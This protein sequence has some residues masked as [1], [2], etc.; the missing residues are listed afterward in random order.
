MEKHQIPE[1]NGSGFLF[2]K[3]PFHNSPFVT[4]SVFLRLIICIYDDA[5]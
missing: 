2:G 3:N 1:P 5:A 4:K